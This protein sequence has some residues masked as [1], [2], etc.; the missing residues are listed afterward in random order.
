VLACA[1][2]GGHFKQLVRLLSRIDDVGSVTWLTYDTGLSRDLLEQAGRCEDRLV[3]APYAT[4]RDLPNLA[5]DA[6][7]AWRLLREDDYDL[8]I[9]TGAGIAVAALP[10]ARARG[11][12]AC[13][14]ET[15]ART[16]G[17]SLS[18]R[19]LQRTP[20]IDLLTQNRSEG[21]ASKWRYGGSVFDG[22]EPGPER[23]LGRGLTRVVVTLGTSEAYGFSRLLERLIQIL[24]HRVDVLWQ[25]GASETTG[26]PIEARNTVPGPELAAA[27]SAA[28]VVVAHAGVGSTLSAFEL[29]CFPI[30]VPRCRAFGENI[31]DHQRV[32]ASALSDRG[33]AL[34]VEVDELNLGHLEAASRRTVIPSTDPPR[35]PI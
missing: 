12:R 32:T 33:L 15:A 21:Y 5:R 7:V 35:L 26:L 4:P 9:S 11:V 17:P 14:I 10:L 18:G 19:I 29:G 2:G 27:M 25:T 8:A 1:S 20:G 3:Y 6:A 24:P 31:D 23:D 16:T 34:H 28:D 22:F 30:L 13:F